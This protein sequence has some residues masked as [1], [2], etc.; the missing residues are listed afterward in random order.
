MQ[1]LD[2]NT[3]VSAIPNSYGAFMSINIGIM[4]FIDSMQFM[5]SSLEKLAENLHDHEDETDPSDQFSGTHTRSDKEDKY[6]HFNFM[7][8]EYPKHYKILSEKGTSR[9]SGS[10]V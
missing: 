2:N 9:V 3:N 4:K 10:M 5:K 8:K 6:K 7:K 1:S